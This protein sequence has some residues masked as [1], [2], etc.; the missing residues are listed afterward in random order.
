MCM[1]KKITAELFGLEIEDLNKINESNM[2]EVVYEFGN[3]QYKLGRLE[4]DGRD[5]DKVY[6]KLLKRKEELSK[7]IDKFFN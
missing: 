2:E 7:I 4:T 1:A 3:V 5:S 6:N